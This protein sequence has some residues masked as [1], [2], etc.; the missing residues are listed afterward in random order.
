MTKQHIQFL[1][2]VTALL[3]IEGGFLYY[4]VHYTPIASDTKFRLVMAGVFLVLIPFNIFAA[5]K[6]S[7]GRPKA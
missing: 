3:L 4:M 1:A 2:I 6:L 7:L 5:W